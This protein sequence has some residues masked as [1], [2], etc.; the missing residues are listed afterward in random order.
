MAE[1]L[2]TYDRR[3]RVF[4]SG[5]LDEFAAERKAL[6]R[7]IGKGMGFTPVVLESHAR[8]HPHRDTYLAQ[9]EQ[10]EVFVGVYG[11]CYGWVDAA[12]GATVSGI[13]DECRSA[14]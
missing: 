8:A 5:D 1:L 4:L 9:I 6:A 10:S 7:M 2:L 14:A 12:A 13:H 11:L 3:I